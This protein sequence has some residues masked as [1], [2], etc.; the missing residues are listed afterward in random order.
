MSV[1]TGSGDHETTKELEVSYA[2]KAS[3]WE[4]GRIVSTIVQVS[5]AP[6]VATADGTYVNRRGGEFVGSV[7]G[8]G[9]TEL[10]DVSRLRGVR[11]PRDSPAR[12]VQKRDT[13]DAGPVSV[14][15]RVPDEERPRVL[16]RR[17]GARSGRRSVLVD[18][19]EALGVA[20]THVDPARIGLEA[21]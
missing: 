14:A 21:V 4:P 10:A 20:R 17:K 12:A 1:T 5:F 13:G 3:T 15:R 18:H 16:V 8:G 6:G 2:G 9:E 7:G 11:R 19:D